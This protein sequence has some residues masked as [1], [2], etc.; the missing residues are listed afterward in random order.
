MAVRSFQTKVE[1]NAPAD[2]VW[3]VLADVLRWPQWLPTVTGVEPLGPP[4]LAAGARYRLTQPKLR[5]AIW[6]V[7]ELVPQRKFNWESRSPGL[8]VLAGHVLIPLSGMS[9][10]SLHN[11][12]MSGPFTGIMDLFAGRLIRE[13]V[14]C[15]AASLKQRVESNTQ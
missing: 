5:P 10:S 9:T 15:E 11:V 4:E 3:A 8:H 6:S 14:E 1:I 7:V 13:Y 2:A 12:T